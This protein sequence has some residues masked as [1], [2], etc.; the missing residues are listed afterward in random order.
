MHWTTLRRCA[1][2]ASRPLSYSGPTTH[3]REV[4]A[5]LRCLEG[6]ALTGALLRI[7]D[8]L[9]TREGVLDVC[10]QSLQA[11]RLA[12]SPDGG[13]VAKLEE[14]ARRLT[15]ALL[16]HERMPPKARLVAVMLE[17]AAAGESSEALRARTAKAVEEGLVPSAAAVAAL[18]R[19][20]A[21]SLDAQDVREMASV[22]EAVQSGGDAAVAALKVAEGRRR[23]RACL[24]AVADAADGV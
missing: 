6:P 21:S 10:L 7:P 15:A 22:A 23:A 4:L 9:M 12:P 3:D 19:A 24:T 20:M 17:A 16:S 1:T 5:A 8:T 14:I 13:E 18:A 11:A 2:H